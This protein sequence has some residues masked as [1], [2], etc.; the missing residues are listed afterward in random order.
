VE[1]VVGRS[2]KVVRSGGAI[3]WDVP[4]GRDGL[5][6]TPFLGQLTGIGKDLGRK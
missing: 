1:K 4:V 6:R 2:R 5:V 3:T